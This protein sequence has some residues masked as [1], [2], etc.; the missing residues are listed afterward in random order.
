MEKIT[1]QDIEALENYF[2]VGENLPNAALEI[3]AQNL[4]NI[5][6]SQ[7][8]NEA[9]FDDFLSKTGAVDFKNEILELKNDHQF[10][11]EIQQSF[12]ILE[13]E[14]LKKKI[15]AIDSAENETDSDITD[16]DISAA[17]KNIERQKLKEKFNEIDTEKGEVFNFRPWAIAASVALIF[18]VGALFFTK[19]QKP[20]E[21]LAKKEPIK[22]SKPLIDFSKTLADRQLKTIISDLPINN[23][24]SLGFASK[25]L[26]F[27]NYI[28]QP[29]IDTLQKIITYLKQ[30]KEAETQINSV[31]KSV[32]SLQNLLNKY[33]FTAN[34]LTFY[35]YKAV[36]PEIFE[37]NG[38]LSITIQKHTYPLTATKPLKSLR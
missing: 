21:Q 8:F 37:D 17:F 20:T 36:K 23:L 11:A 34:K 2:A 38:T 27:E 10:Q 33:T 22:T 26:Q 14:N 7:S 32:D 29:R 3:F 18:T 4:K 24:G 16:T 13:R 15:S 31:K 1:K 28:L 6:N 25:P 30:N 35:S 19:N 5:F 9:A 12:I